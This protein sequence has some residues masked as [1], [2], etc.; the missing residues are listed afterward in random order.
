MDA[1]A[2]KPNPTRA[3]I[4]RAQGR[5]TA[6]ADVSLWTAFAGFIA[7][8]P[9]DGDPAEKLLQLG[10][11]ED[12]LVGCGSRYRSHLGLSIRFVRA[13]SESLRRAAPQR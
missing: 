7:R 13:T 1:V 4:A 5:L 3:R 9:T 11:L 6:D 12:R 8:S 10:C 2:K